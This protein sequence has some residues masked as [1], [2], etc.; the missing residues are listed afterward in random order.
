MPGTYQILNKYSLKGGR[1]GKRDGGQQMHDSNRSG[2]ASTGY[3]SA[4]NID[5]SKIS[6]SF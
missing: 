4:N 2:K 3:M 5:R 1:E 6:D